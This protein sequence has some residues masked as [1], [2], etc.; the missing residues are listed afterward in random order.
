MRRDKEKRSQIG[1]KGVNSTSEILFLKFGSPSIGHM[2][3]E[4]VSGNS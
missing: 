4:L 3:M 2:P 1:M